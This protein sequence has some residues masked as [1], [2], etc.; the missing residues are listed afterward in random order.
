MSA[1]RKTMRAR[2]H[3]SSFFQLSSMGARK[4]SK[5]IPS[6]SIQKK[7]FCETQCLTQK[8]LF[9]MVE[10]DSAEDLT[11]NCVSISQPRDRRFDIRIKLNTGPYT[12]TLRQQSDRLESCEHSR[13]VFR[14]TLRRSKLLPARH[15]SVILQRL[16]HSQM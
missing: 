5:E 16:T 14:S 9:A 15:C 6:L 2:V 1:I 10:I 4:A 11:N 7:H 3:D 12:C 8:A 13:T